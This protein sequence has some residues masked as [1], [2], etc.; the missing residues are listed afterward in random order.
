MNSK[1]ST[2]QKR[3]EKRDALMARYEKEAREK[4]AHKLELAKEH[5][6]ADHPKL[7]LLYEKAWQHGHANG[8]NEVAFWFED[9]AELVR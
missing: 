8:W 7:D 2:Q 9:L 4:Q 5:G 1:L 6:L 3:A